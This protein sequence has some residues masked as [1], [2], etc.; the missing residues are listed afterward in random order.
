MDGPYFILAPGASTQNRRWPI[1]KFAVLSKE[2]S[3]WKGWKIVVIGNKQEAEHGDKLKVLLPETE[4][5]NL[6][7]RLSLPESM[8][9]VKNATLLISN[10][11]APIHMAATTG[12]P[13]ICI[14]QGNHFGRWNPYPK[15]VAPWIETVY[16]AG[17]GDITENYQLL[18]N[19][20]H[21]GSDWPV[22]DVE[23]PEILNL[24]RRIIQQGKKPET[25]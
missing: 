18:V 3:E 9:V 12:T 13:A 21:D 11:S 5:T 2:V 10:E 19:Q 6:A 25:P 1:E 8:V 15:T 4:I 23:V 16:P 24:I 17:F 22:S 14:S 20:F 7:G